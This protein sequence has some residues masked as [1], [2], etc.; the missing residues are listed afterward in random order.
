MIVAVTGATGYIGR[1]VVAQLQQHHVQVRTLARPST[2]QTGFAAPL[3]W[4]NGTLSDVAALTQ[5]VE[6]VDAVVHLAYEHIPGRYR[7][8]E[9]DDLAGW[10]DANVQGTLQLLLAARAA[11]VKKFIFLSSRAVFSSTEAG[12]ELDETHPISPNTHYGAYKAAIE[13][14]LRSFASVEGMQT[15]SVRATGVYGLTHPPERSKWYA[16]VAAVLRGEQV[17]T[18]RGGTEVHG[19][20]VARTIWALLSQSEITTDIVHLSDL[21]VTHRQ[22][23]ELVQEISGIDGALPQPPAQPPSNMLVCRSIKTLGIELGGKQRLH[24]TLKEL[25]TVVRT[26]PNIN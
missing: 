21:Y 1:F 9:G 6:G 8:G 14:F 16:L 7:G 22:L 20:D 12:R 19:V 18:R 13:A 5:L 2:N 15:V 11:R 17:T 25:V 4:I 26:Q 24:N 10:L 3:T 23:V